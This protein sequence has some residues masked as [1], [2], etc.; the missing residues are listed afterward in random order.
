MPVSAGLA[1]FVADCSAIDPHNQ[2][3]TQPQN[4]HHSGYK[5]QKVILSMQYCIF[6]AIAAAGTDFDPLSSP[7]SMVSTPA[8]SSK[9]QKTAVLHII[10][11]LWRIHGTKD[12]YT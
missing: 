6:P 5:R 3:Q 7:W 9:K 1:V 12:T 11:P 8:P 10:E 2:Q 4:R